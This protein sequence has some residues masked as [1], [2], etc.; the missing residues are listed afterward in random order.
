MI[1]PRS[2]VQA[3]ILLLIYVFL[4]FL[5]MGVV[6][7]FLGALIN[8]SKSDVWRFGWAD[9]V[10]LFPGVFAYALPVGAGILVQSWL[11]DRKR[12]KSDSG[13]G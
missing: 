3:F 8:Y 4:L 1:K 11:K 2:R 13:E 6:A 12:S 10:D 7:K 9:I 5:L